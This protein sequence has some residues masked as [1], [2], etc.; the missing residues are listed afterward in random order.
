MKNET[1]SRSQS[2][3]VTIPSPDIT[4]LLSTLERM[5]LAGN[6]VEKVRAQLAEASHWKNAHPDLQFRWAG[7]AQMA[8]EIET[9]SMVL[10]HVNRE[11]PSHLGAWLARLELLKILDDRNGIARLV[12]LAGLS[13]PDSVR[14]ALKEAMTTVQRNPRQDSDV[15]AAEAPF[16]S[17][18]RRTATLQAFIDL[19]SGKED[20]FARQWVEKESGKTG[21]V[22]VRRP[23]EITDVEEHLSGRKTYGIY[24]LRGDGKVHASV[25]DADLSAEYRQKPVD[26]DT[27]ARIFRER[28]Y[29]IARIQELSRQRGLR[30]NAE[31]SGGKG[32]HF[33]Y[34]F[35]PPVSASDIRGVLGAVQQILA[36][37]LTTFNLELF[38]KQDA[39]TGKGFGNLV[40]LPLGV[41]RGTGKRSYFIACND[42][43]T[44]AQLYFVSKIEK[45][46][47]TA[48]AGKSPNPPENLLKHPRWEKWAEEWPELNTLAGRCPPLGGLFA[49]CRNRRV[50]DQKEMKVLYQTVGFLPRAKTL[51]HYLME[52]QPEYNPHLVEYRLSRLRGT[53]LGCRRIHSLLNMVLDLCEFD[54]DF[55]YRHPLLHLGEWE[56]KGSGRSETA[57]SLT[58]ALENLKAAI[59]QVEH[60]IKTKTDACP[61]P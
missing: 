57:T 16:V 5:I 1:I 27:R 40:K 8:G 7:L 43:S 31:F 25:L 58:D 33:W 48:L 42:R 54:A 3:A 30:A 32:F 34:F 39:P 20:A 49:A 24:L 60:F 61:A 11:N 10:E 51:M 15:T 50:L 47:L 52:S 26:K 19:F 28:D 29:L 4:L 56:K 21:Y 22:P 13:A 18:R 17:M 45:D 6:E 37:D 38:P 35:D 14:A 59:L 46:R 44:E 23:M 9:A 36:K 55:E 2:S 41:H 53:P 12:S